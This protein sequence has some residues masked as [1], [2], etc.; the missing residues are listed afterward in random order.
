MFGA[1]V[2][3]GLEDAAGKLVSVLQGRQDLLTQL[4]SKVKNLRVET[5]LGTRSFDDPLITAAMLGYNREQ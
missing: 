1:K 3:K 2:D 4:Q 5:Y